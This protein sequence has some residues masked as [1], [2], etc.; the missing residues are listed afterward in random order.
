MWG[1]DIPA[2]RRHPQAG[3]IVSRFGRAVKN[4]Y[5][6]IDRAQ[7]R[8]YLGTCLYEEGGATC[9]AELWV[10][11]GAGHVKCSQCEQVHDVAQ[12]RAWLLEQAAGL[13]VTAQ[14]A[15]RYVTKYGDVEVTE[16]SIRNWVARGKVKLRPGLSTQ[17]QFELSALLDYIATR[18]QNSRTDSV[19]ELPVAV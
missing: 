12:R 19:A 18:V 1:D 6:A 15:A 7:E 2:V 14:E 8:F 5:S 4:A 11:E 9:H 10:K 17:R 13:V 3:E 16:A